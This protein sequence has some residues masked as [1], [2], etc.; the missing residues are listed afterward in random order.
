M[1]PLRLM[2]T[3]D[4]LFCFNNLFY[5]EISLHIVVKLA[6]K[7]VWFAGTFYILKRYINDPV[8]LAGL[9]ASVVLP[10]EY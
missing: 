9:F 8:T 7:G 2:I 1:V 6:S 5:V 3:G 4:M 10:Q